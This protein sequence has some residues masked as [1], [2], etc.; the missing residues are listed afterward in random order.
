MTAADELIIRVE[1][2][3]NEVTLDSLMAVV[4]HVVLMLEDVHAASSGGQGA[5]VH[6]KWRVE[7]AR[8]ERA[9][10][11]RLRPARE[12]DRDAVLRVVR[13]AGVNVR[14]AVAGRMTAGAVSMYRGLAR[15][16]KTVRGNGVLPPQITFGDVGTVTP[17][18]G[19]AK[20]IRR[21]DETRRNVSYGR[22]TLQGTLRRV[23]V[24]GADNGRERDPKFQLHVTAT[25]ALVDCDFP[26]TMLNQVRNN[27]AIPPR[28]LAV[29][30]RAK[31]NGD[32]KPLSIRVERLEDIPSLAELRYLLTEP[33]VPVGFLPLN[34]LADMEMTGGIDVG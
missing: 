5:V 34:F 24:P 11:I 19:L 12:T 16:E 6:L 14:E 8:M 33:P 25:D 26:R 4:R 22:T 1:P 23:S 29:T 27:L 10:S 7:D 20:A 18:H 17:S 30:G 32:G 3:E 21:F 28:R 2:K 13:L 15:I 9:V 31:Y